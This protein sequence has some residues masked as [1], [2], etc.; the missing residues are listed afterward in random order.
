MVAFLAFG[1]NSEP[2]LWVHGSGGHS[3]FNRTDDVVRLF[4]ETFH[5]RY[6]VE[7]SAALH[8]NKATGT[9]T[10]WKDCRADEAGTGNHRA[11]KVRKSDGMGRQDE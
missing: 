9:G 6:G 4:T 2:H 3:S 8:Y 10:L 5:K 11:V 1:R 7:C